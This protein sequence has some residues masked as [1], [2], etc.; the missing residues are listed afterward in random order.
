MMNDKELLSIGEASRIT[1]MHVKSLRYYDRMGVFTPEY[2]DPK[3]GYRYYCFDQLQQILAVKACLDTG[4]VLNELNDYRL[5]GA[6]DYPRLFSE[7]GKRLDDKIALLK[8]I[9]GCLEFLDEEV[10]FND[11][12][13]ASNRRYGSVALWRTPIGADDIHDFSRKDV[14]LRLASDASKKGY[15]VNPIYFGMM[16]TISG[17]R[18]ELYAIAGLTESAHSG[19]PC[20]NVYFT[21]EAWYRGAARSDL[22]VTAAGEVFPDLMDQDYDK[23][24]FTTVSLKS[25]CSEPAYSMYINEPAE[26]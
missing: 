15:Q 8:R 10:T 25:S 22:D 17:G 20:E 7:A 13:A 24:V 14:F 26:L 1:G 11:G 12:M 5:D 6:I 3:S 9:K 4:I 2:V 19:E 23:V 21:P 16:M 18:R